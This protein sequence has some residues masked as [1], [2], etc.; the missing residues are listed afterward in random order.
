MRNR[1]GLL[2]WRLIVLQYGDTGVYKWDEAPL[3]SS[4]SSNA[5]NA[6]G[7]NSAEQPRLNPAKLA[8]QIEGLVV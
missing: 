7:L 5:G 3:V 4:S 6:L 1:G 8:R 2:R